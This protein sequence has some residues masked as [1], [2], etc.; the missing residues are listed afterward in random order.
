[1]SYSK[2]HAS[3][4][5]YTMLAHRYPVEELETF[6]SFNSRL[7]APEHDLNARR[8]MLPVFGHGLSIGGYGLQPGSP[9]RTSGPMWSVEKDAQ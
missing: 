9:R 2:G 3:M 6:R 7:R 4:N 1:M 8:D 5:L